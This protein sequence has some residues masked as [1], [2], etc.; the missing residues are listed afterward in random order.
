MSFLI[1]VKSTEPNV[2]YN[3]SMDFPEA[4]IIDPN[5]RVN[6]VSLYYERE[7][8]VILDADNSYMYVRLGHSTNPLQILHLGLAQSTDQKAHATALTN[9]QLSADQLANRIEDRFNDTFGGLGYTI[10]VRHLPDN[11][12]E[13]TNYFKVIKTSASNPAKTDQ[14]QGTSFGNYAPSTGNIDCHGVTLQ[15]SNYLQISQP[16]Q[17]TNVPSQALGG[18]EWSVGIEDAVGAGPNDAFGEGFLIALVAEAD[19]ASVL[20]NQA[21]K[22][23]NNPQNG[24]ATGGL[25]C[26]ASLGYFTR[27][28]GQGFIQI[29]EHGGPSAGVTPPIPITLLGGARVGIFLVTGE[30]AGEHSVKYFYKQLNGPI[31]YVSPTATA[32]KV[33]LSDWVDK[34]IY[35]YIGVDTPT[36]NS[37]QNMLVTTGIDDTKLV[38]VDFEDAGNPKIQRGSSQYLQNTAHSLGTNIFIR[39]D[40]NANAEDNLD[41]GMVT[42]KIAPTRHSKLSFTLPA[43]W[44]NPLFPPLPAVG[45]SIS[46]SIVDEA[47]RLANI[48]AGQILGTD[49][50]EGLVTD[51]AGGDRGNPKNPRYL[52]F[53]ITPAG[54]LQYRTLQDGDNVNFTT[55]EDLNVPA[56]NLKPLE[57]V[58]ET[59]AVSNIA[60]L[61]Y[62]PVSHLPV[63]ASKYSAWLPL[64]NYF[65]G[66]HG[67]AGKPSTAEYRYHFNIGKWDWAFSQDEWWRN[68]PISNIAMSVEDPTVTPDTKGYMEMLIDDDDNDSLGSIIGF[69]KGSYIFDKNN[70]T[71]I[72]ERPY[73]PHYE[74]EN[75]DRSLFIN[76]PTLNL[77]NVI[78]QKYVKDSTIAGGPSGNLQG[79]NRYVAKVPRYHQEDSSHGGNV[80]KSNS[81]PFYYDYF[82]Y[83]VPLNNATEVILNGLQLT[84]TT[85]DNKSATDIVYSEV[86]LSITK[87]ESAGQGDGPKIGKPMDMPQSFSQRNIQKSQMTPSLL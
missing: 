27:T 59:H 70:T 52:E 15:T 28:N 39:K 21:V 53:Q 10:Q 34:T 75:P 5:S 43:D 68:Q 14:T 74:T 23:V 7:D 67:V 62:T 72:G 32:R 2:G 60:R 29:I 79:I 85:D 47:Q 71:V 45:Q 49:S 87:V 19:V 6:L 69:K 50:D 77:R 16:I 36:I 61:K 81:G 26:L 83:S 57:F 78:G 63:T 51:G 65:N 82:P 40:Y 76:C 46:W 3:Y 18:S 37:F 48:T 22:P 35:P 38:N 66:Q 4:L 54:L 12:F 56:Y 73:D 44:F 84:I 24:T 33:T 55:I 41:T 9:P 11:T 86:L 58:L 1:S 42:P 20:G 31:T 13:I 25:Q 30:E 8:G 17:T 80:A 64:P